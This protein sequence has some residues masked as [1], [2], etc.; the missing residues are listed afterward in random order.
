MSK[1]KFP[2]GKVKIE[3]ESK[4]AAKIG[5]P[6]DISLKVNGKEVSQ[7]QVPFAFD[8]SIGITNVKYLKK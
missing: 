4:L 1:E 7:G 2:T 3:I 6:M 8:G 5:G